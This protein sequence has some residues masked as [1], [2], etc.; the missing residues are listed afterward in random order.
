MSR[1]RP[2]KGAQVM[3][4]LIKAVFKTGSGSSASMILSAISS[5]I[6]AVVSGPFGIG[7]YSLIQ[8]LVQTV[9]TTGIAG[10]GKVV[11]TQGVASREG[12][13]RDDFIVTAFWILFI[14]AFISSVSLVFLAPWIAPLV[15]GTSDGATVGLVRWVA[16]PVVLA[17]ALVYLNG[18]LNGFMAIGRLAMIQVAGAAMN[19]LLSYPISVM[20]DTGYLVAFVAMTTASIFVQ[21]S[22]GLSKVIRHGYLRAIVANGFRFRIRKQAA[23]SF[24][25]VALTMMV[26]SIV[27]SVS[28][29]LVRALI[30]QYDGIEEAGF[31]NVAWV[32]CMVYPTI[33]L[34]SFG[35]YYLPKL[36]QTKN[37][38]ERSELMNK[39]FRLTAILI[40]PLEL[41][42]VVLKPLLIDIL[43]SGEFYPSLLM[44]R[45]M[46]IGIHLK[47]ATSVF[48][49]P[50][51]SFADMRTYFWT[52]SL[53]HI[54]L[55]GFTIMAVA[56][57][58]SLEMIGV[59]YVVVYA[60]YLVYSLHYARTQHGYAAERRPV[61][62]WIVG[63]FMVV[64]ASLITWSDT[65]IN[66]Y[67]VAAVV[68]GGLL[69]L[70]FSV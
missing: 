32:I 52:S 20:V 35:A 49:M 70:A 10:G 48:A 38:R 28:L 30:V 62:T 11:L 24:F 57:F 3:R 45:W 13:D 37:H 68:I 39:V 4:E 69:Y 63:M 67:V 60:L 31:F 7:L 26:A 9:S 61:I 25:V 6:M 42:V 44:L 29:L 40:V 14:G 64:G 18:V 65:S 41:L 51:F 55:V 34:S 22:I 23:R 43:Y 53:W 54:G 46:I 1:L 12:Q 47:A 36:S 50:M 66:L 5:K 16:L 59:G 17:I 19:A 8:Q 58:E 21:V 15:F 2:D 33:V 27:A 56:H